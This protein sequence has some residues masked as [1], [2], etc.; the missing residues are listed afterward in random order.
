MKE[1]GRSYRCISSDI[2]KWIAVAAMCI[3]HLAVV[4]LKGYVNIKLADIPQEQLRTWE[5]F[6][7]WM[8]NVGRMAFP[9]FA[10]MLVEGFYHS[11]NRKKYGMRLLILALL[12]EIPYDLAI[13]RAFWSMT[14][15]NTVFT[16]LLG[17]LVLLFVER[18]HRN[19][20]EYTNGKGRELLIFTQLIAVAA[21]GLLAYVCRVD[22]TWKGIL[23]IAV[24]YFFYGY[25]GA[26]AVS[27]FCVF[28]SS[29]WSAPAFLLIPFY[30]GKR[31]G[32][33]RGFYLLYPM[34]LLLLWGTLQILLL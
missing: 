15:Q 4:V 16:L 1:L 19:L 26:A 13:N 21:G 24:F 23:L 22:Y 34:H 32:K 33:G 20:S 28:S 5:L 8:R 27:G 31:S 3:D 29:P 17:F 10:F 18:L 25:R 2:L 14:R 12:S 9:L 30:N 6:Y 7:D 11:K